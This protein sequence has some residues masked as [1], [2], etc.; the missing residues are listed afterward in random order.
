LALL[1]FAAAAG[2]AV[3]GGGLPLEYFVPGWLAAGGGEDFTGGGVLPFE[4]DFP[5]GE[6]GMTEDL[7]TE[8]LGRADFPTDGLGEG[9]GLKELPPDEPDRLP[10]L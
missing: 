4:Y 2:G 3:A 7:P 10:L 9:D 6:A 5:C 1:L 8:G